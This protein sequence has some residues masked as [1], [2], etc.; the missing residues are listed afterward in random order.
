MKVPI[1]PHHL[2]N[3]YYAPP[4]IAMTGN[5]LTVY[6]VMKC[7]LLYNKNKHDQHT[8]PFCAKIKAGQRFANLMYA[9]LLHWLW[10]LAYHYRADKHWWAWISIYVIVGSTSSCLQVIISTTCVITITRR[11]Q[12]PSCTRRCETQQVCTQVAARFAWLL[13][14]VDPYGS[15]DSRTVCHICVER[16]MLPVIQLQL[17]FAPYHVFGQYTWGSGLDAAAGDNGFSS[18]QQSCSNAT[19]PASVFWHVRVQVVCLCCVSDRLHAQ[20]RPV[21][22]PRQHRRRLR[23]LIM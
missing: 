15:G 4:P 10:I 8:L 3:R 18:Q 16:N 11:R 9:W 21:A 17:W 19:L 7:K 20:P 6:P 5:H 13:H 2:E 23:I 12:H 22:T 1:T 14:T